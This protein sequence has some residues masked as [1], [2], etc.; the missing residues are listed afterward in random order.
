MIT[1]DYA[2]LLIAEYLRKKGR[3]GIKCF[4]EDYRD[5]SKYEVMTERGF[6]K[7]YTE[8]TEYLRDYNWI[9]L[10]EFLESECFRNVIPY[11]NQ[12]DSLER[13]QKVQLEDQNTW[14]T[15]EK[16]RSH[17][18]AVSN[19]LSSKTDEELFNNLNGYWELKEINSFNKNKQIE[20][21]SIFLGISIAKETDFGSMVMLQLG[22]QKFDLLTGVLFLVQ[23]STHGSLR[24]IEAVGQFWRR[25]NPV[26]VAKNIKFSL[27]SPDYVEFQ[28]R[29]QFGND[30]LSTT[31][32]DSKIWN[33]DADLKELIDSRLKSVLP[34]HD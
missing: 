25:K 28:V 4:Y 27:R 31:D 8:E 15:I 32:L 13:L 16:R 1:Q 21:V 30:S 12:P 22:D 29:L 14:N 5:F 19:R 23:S 3:K 33:P 7:W 2:R 6:Y 17:E 10:S 26:S 24:I 18:Q 20:G 11:L 34:H 9:P